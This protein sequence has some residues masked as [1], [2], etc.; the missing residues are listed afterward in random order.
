MDDYDSNKKEA[1]T[2]R[3]WL[4][5]LIITISREIGNSSN[6]RWQLK[7]NCE[8]NYNDKNGSTDQTTDW[9]A[10]SLHEIVKFQHTPLMTC[11]YS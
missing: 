4:G 2:S 9:S 5:Y 1:D 3:Y 7:I 10:V 11:C 8:K 6:Y